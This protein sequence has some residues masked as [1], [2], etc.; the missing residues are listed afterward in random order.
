MTVKLLWV[1]PEPAKAIEYA[2]RLC[3][4]SHDKTKEGSASK[5]I[6]ACLNKGHYSITEHA[7]A[8][9]EVSE[10]SRALLAQLSRHRFL[11]LCVRSQR[12]CKEDSFGA[13]R[14]SFICKDKH[15]EQEQEQLF[16]MA[17]EQ[18]QEI[19]TSLLNHGMKAEDA[20]GVLPNACHTRFVVTA[21][22][23]AF[24]E[25]LGKR[26]DRAAQWEIRNMA[27]EMLVELYNVCPDVFGGMME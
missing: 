7:S 23:R 12:Y 21:N 9:F 10:V 24:Y 26:T 4:D 13:V 14:P 25:F 3:Y 2:A 19:Y 27:N 8:S 5:L 22:F 6:K 15:M 16:E 20:R 1:S 17:L 18:A 11:S